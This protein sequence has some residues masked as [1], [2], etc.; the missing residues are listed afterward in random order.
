M[1]LIKLFC[2][3][4]FFYSLTC[5]DIILDDIYIDIERISKEALE[6]NASYSLWRIYNGISNGADT[7]GN[8]SSAG[9]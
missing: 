2:R 9:C 7:V 5:W 6:D 8:Y 1:N 3:R 4:Q